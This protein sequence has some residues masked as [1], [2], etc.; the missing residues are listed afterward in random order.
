MDLFKIKTFLMAAELKSLSKA[1]KN[2]GYAPS[3]LSHM[4]ASLE[5]ELGIK[6]FTRSYAGIEPT[7]NAKKLMPLFKMAIN[8]QEEIMLACEKMSTGE[9]TL[10]IG[11]YSSISKVYLPKI[12]R[13]FNK[14]YPFI[15]VSISVANDFPENFEAD[16]DIIF[17]ENNKEK[18]EWIP[19]FE[20]EYMAAVKKGRFNKSE[21]VTLDDLKQYPFILPCDEKVKR[22]CAG[23]LSDTMEVSSDDDGAIISMVKEGVGNTIL[24]SLSLYEQ[25]DI[26]I[27]EI[28]PRLTRTLGLVY[29]KEKFTKNHRLFINF[30]KKYFEKQ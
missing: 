9:N 1:A 12:I 23:K 6:L 4:M 19:L 29:G 15:H 2:L 26:D 5:S 10:R 18:K 28:L 21:K 27:K 3:A 16:F 7:D 17:A 20:D 11:T 14:E 8:T 13:E 30:V 25:N 22:Y 24:P